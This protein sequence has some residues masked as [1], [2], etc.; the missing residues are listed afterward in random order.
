M[1]IESPKRRDDSP[2]HSDDSGFHGATTDGYVSVFAAAEHSRSGSI[3]DEMD[4]RIAKSRTFGILSPLKLDS[5]LSSESR[6]PV[7]SPRAP[8][9]SSQ[10]PSL[11]SQIESEMEIKRANAA[12][13]TSAIISNPQISV[14]NNI[15]I[16]QQPQQRPP[17]SSKTVNP[18]QDDE[19]ERVEEKEIKSKPFVAAS[20]NHFNK[21]E[22]PPAII[23][24]RSTNPFDEDDSESEAEK[25]KEEQIAE[26]HFGGD[27]SP[28]PPPAFE[29]QQHLQKRQQQSEMEP[30]Q[31]TLRS[32]ITSTKTTSSSS[33][34]PVINGKSSRKSSSGSGSGNGN[35]LRTGWQEI[36]EQQRERSTSPPKS[37]SSS[38]T[39]TT[40]IVKSPKTPRAVGVSHLVKQ[41]ASLQNGEIPAPSAPPPPP[42]KSYIGGGNNGYRAAYSQQPQQQQQTFSTFEERRHAAANGSRSP[43]SPRVIVSSETP[44]YSS[45]TSLP[46]P[47]PITSRRTS[48][49]NTFQ[50]SNSSNSIP[51]PPRREP[52]PK[53]SFEESKKQTEGICLESRNVAI[54]RQT[55]NENITPPKNVGNLDFSKYADV[56]PIGRPMDSTTDESEDEIKPKNLHQQHQQ[57]SD[58]S[59]VVEISPEQ[60]TEIKRTLKTDFDKYNIFTVILEKDKGF[61]DSSVGLILTSAITQSENYITIQ[62]VIN[63]SIADKSDKLQKGDRIFFV[64]GESTSNLTCHETREKIKLAAPRVYLIVGRYAKAIVVGTDANSREA[65]PTFTDDPATLQY[66]PDPIKVVLRKSDLGCGIAMDGG[67]ASRYGNRPIVVKKIFSVGEAARDGRLKLGD[68]ISSINGISMEGK[69]QL[70]AWKI[71]KSCPEGNV[72]FVVYKRID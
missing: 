47:K 20:V 53:R 63:R 28:I 35:G 13:K 32:F 12:A 22:A 50:Y 34:P 70:D 4:R 23:P 71:L 64:Q 55:L 7:P 18:F 57:E 43:K 37:P 59:D 65:V 6:S 15:E 58:A 45:S 21:K 30:L 10:Q 38:A 44:K 39:T 60:I 3:F 5:S 1:L 49:N 67:F 26:M 54:V 66:S 40:I 61:D 56:K 2:T 19:Y 29:R 24:R 27:S 9:R 11:I 17:H 68:Q 72:E 48:E 16:K 8:S 62:R 31:S 51:S 33:S 69:T 46:S 14:N 42:P 36:K 52:S 25:A 41:F